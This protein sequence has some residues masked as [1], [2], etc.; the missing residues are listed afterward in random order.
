MVSVH[1]PRLRAGLLSS[2]PSVPAGEVDPF[3]P[4]AGNKEGVLCENLTALGGKG[5]KTLSLMRMGTR[6]AS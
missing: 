4:L 2:T 1:V 3:P 5:A 6:G